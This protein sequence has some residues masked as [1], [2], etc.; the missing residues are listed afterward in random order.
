M[1]DKKELTK[2]RI[3]NAAVKLI[4]V[5]GFN[6]T[7]TA[8]IAK[9]AQISEAIIFRYF[10]SKQNLLK[11]I[12]KH[13]LDQIIENVSIQPFLE[14]I[15]LSQNYS[16]HEFIKAIILERLDYIEKNQ[17]L[18]KVCLVELQYNEELLNLMNAMIDSKLN[19]I[20][21]DIARIIANKLEIPV[22]KAYLTMRIYIGVILTYFIQNFF[23]PI[24]IDRAQM[25]TEIDK[26]SEILNLF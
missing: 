24:K 5:N 4:S 20:F 25:E 8:S 12:V 1:G 2:Q 6:A 23:L 19:P 22:Q 3:I 18:I 10:E 17:E 21:G 14:N 15:E 16:P 7:S 26:I 9:E 13:A 11:E